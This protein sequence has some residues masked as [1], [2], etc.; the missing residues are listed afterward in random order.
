MRFV[1]YLRTPLRQHKTTP[2]ILVVP[3]TNHLQLHLSPASKIILRL[4][5]FI[6][7]VA[8]V[9]VVLKVN[10]G[11]VVS[12]KILEQHCCFRFSS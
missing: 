2:S 6:L 5:L 7:Q 4:V 3:S 9:V 8:T 11:F 12:V 10:P 1:I